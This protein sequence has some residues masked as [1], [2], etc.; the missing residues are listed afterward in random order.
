MFLKTGVGTHF[1]NFVMYCNYCV[2]TFPEIS[3]FQSHH[4]YLNVFAVKFL[5]YQCF[6]LSHSKM[7]SV[8]RFLKVLVIIQ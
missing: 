5:I 6:P 7:M 2:N 8:A 4:A 3:F 1:F